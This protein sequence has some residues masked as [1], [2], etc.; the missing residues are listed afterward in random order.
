MQPGPTGVGYFTHTRPT[1]G[2]TRS[3]FGVGGGAVARMEFLSSYPTQYTP[4]LVV[5]SVGK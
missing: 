5:V 4:P 1:P 2:E 3:G